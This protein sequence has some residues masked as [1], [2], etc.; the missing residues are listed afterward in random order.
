MFILTKKYQ[1]GL[2]WI[3]KI[4]LRLF[5]AWIICVNI[6]KVSRIA[7]DIHVDGLVGMIIVTIWRTTSTTKSYVRCWNETVALLLRSSISLWSGL[8]D[9]IEMKGCK[10]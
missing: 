3:L 1:Y 8:Y 5:E 4:T 7:M 10:Q 6:Q 9:P 2:T